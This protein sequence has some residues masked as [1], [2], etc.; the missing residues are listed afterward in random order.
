MVR[1]RSARPGSIAKQ[2][3]PGVADECSYPLLAGRCSIE[4]VFDKA[5][6]G[7]SPRRSHSV[8]VT[9]GSGRKAKAAITRRLSRLIPAVSQERQKLCRPLQLPGNNRA[10]TKNQ[11]FESQL[12]WMSA[13]STLPALSISCAG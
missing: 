10:V 11:A 7:L 9:I 5:G 13:A 6:R 1:G 12:G 2:S 3:A 4:R 8:D